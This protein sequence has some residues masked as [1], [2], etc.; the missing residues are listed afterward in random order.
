MRFITLTEF[1]NDNLIHVNV[2][3]V[4]AVRYADHATQILCAEG[5]GFFVKDPPEQVLKALS[6]TLLEG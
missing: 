3:R 5:L 4:V 6:T 1:G 2:S